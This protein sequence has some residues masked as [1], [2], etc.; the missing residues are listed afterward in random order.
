MKIIDYQLQW[1]PTCK[2]SLI[3]KFIFETLLLHLNFKRKI[4]W[5]GIWNFTLS[6]KFQKKVTLTWHINRARY[7]SQFLLSIIGFQKKTTRFQV[8]PPQPLNIKTSPFFFFLPQKEKHLGPILLLIFFC[9]F[10]LCIRTLW[11]FKFF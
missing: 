6:F 3:W 7:G 9:V 11:S 10:G 5:H 4:P 1:N 2:V 8:A